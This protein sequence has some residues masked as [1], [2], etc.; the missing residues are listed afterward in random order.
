MHFVYFRDFSWC[1]SIHT[2]LGY[3]RDLWR[4][5]LVGGSYQELE[6]R[7]F[8][9]LKRENEEMKNLASQEFTRPCKCIP[10]IYTGR[11]NVYA[12]TFYFEDLEELS[13][14]LF[15][16]TRPCKWNP[17]VYTGRVNVSAVFKVVLSSYNSDNQF[18][19]ELGRI[20]GGEETIFRAFTSRLTLGKHFNFFL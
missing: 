2:L 4:L 12:R 15:L 16:F 1:N 5:D 7:S 18:W 6:T 17:L 9:A 11:V 19:G 3:F 13:I 20:L 10:I 14:L 8:G